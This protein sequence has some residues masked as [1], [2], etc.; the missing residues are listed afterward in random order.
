MHTY[1]RM[2]IYTLIQARKKKQVF[3]DSQFHT[4]HYINYS[5]FQQFNQFDN[6]SKYYIIHKFTPFIY[7][8][9]FL[10]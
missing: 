6:H 2:Y 8:F 1:I 5:I 9:F 7:L 4:F 10:L 3:Q